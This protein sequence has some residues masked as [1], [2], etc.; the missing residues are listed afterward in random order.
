MNKKQVPTAMSTLNRRLL[1]PDVILQCL[2]EPC[3]LLHQFLMAQPKDYVQMVIPFQK[4]HFSC[5]GQ[6][7]VNVEDLIEMLKQE[8]ANISILKLFCMYELSILIFS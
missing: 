8:E 6:L 2:S 1:L 3:P 4:D 7:I 5:A